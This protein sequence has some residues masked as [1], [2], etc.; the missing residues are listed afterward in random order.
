MAKAST[1]IL[2]IKLKKLVFS[3]IHYN[4]SCEEFSIIISS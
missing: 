1:G 3:V 4:F 2:C